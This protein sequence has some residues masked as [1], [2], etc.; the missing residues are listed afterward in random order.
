LKVAYHAPAISD[1]AFYPLLVLDAALTGAYGLNLWSSFRLPPPQRSTRLYRSLVGKGLASAVNGSL[2][3][4][5]RPFVYII[6]V[7]ATDGTPLE[8]VERELADELGRV[9]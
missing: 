9:D 7:T 1:P 6:S 2:L 3:P 5:E 4:T 8:A